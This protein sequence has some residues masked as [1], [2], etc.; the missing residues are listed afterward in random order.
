MMGNLQ[1][2]TTSDAHAWNLVLSASAW[3][4]FYHRPEYHCLAERDD[5]H[6]ARLFVY[7]QGDDFIALPLV[8][9]PLPPGLAADNLFDA[10]SVYGYAGPIFS[11]LG[12]VE[13]LG[14]GFRASLTDAMIRHRVITVFSRLNPLLEQRGGFGDLGEFRSVGQT[15]SIDLAVPSDRRLSEYRANHRRDIRRLIASGLT[16]YVDSGFDSLAE[17]ERLYRD[18]MS[19]AGAN[20]N[21]FFDS[22]Y[23]KEL[24]EAGTPPPELIVSSADGRIVCAGIFFRQHNVAQYHLSGTASDFRGKAPLKLLIHY[25][26]ERY[27][28]EGLE[29]LHLGGG[30]H[31]MDDAL[32]HFKKGFSPRWHEFNV[33]QWVVDP[34]IY[35][36]LVP[37]PRLGAFFPEYRRPGA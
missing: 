35:Q 27:G 8:L 6:Q 20:D 5:G 18:T 29:T 22:L 32:L 24:I 2:L 26:A 12:V 13:E 15:V 16:C 33:W 34:V 11:D 28:A 14:P 3:H 36:E 31:G 9:R 4:D 37:S 19:R 25:A 30:V 7:R 10:A 21:Y 1:E 17:F 23:F